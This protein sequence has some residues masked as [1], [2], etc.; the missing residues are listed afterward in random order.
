MPENPG[1]HVRT[2]NATAS[3]DGRPNSARRTS[4]LVVD[5]LRF[6]ILP[7]IKIPNLGS[8]ILATVHRRLPSDWTERY[9]TTPMLIETLVESP[10]HRRRLQHP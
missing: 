3:S 5:Y 2:R 10:P 6:L 1:T 9:N 7:W 8:H 4:P